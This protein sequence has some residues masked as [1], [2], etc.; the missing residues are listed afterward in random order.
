MIEIVIKRLLEEK[1]R[2]AHETLEKPGDGSPFEFGPG[3]HV[4]RPKPSDG[5]H[6]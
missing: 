4:R 6:R 2:I 5:N 1:S 3:W